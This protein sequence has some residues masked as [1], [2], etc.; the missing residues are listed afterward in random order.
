[1]IG[2]TTPNSQSL[3]GVSPSVCYRTNGQ[4]QTNGS[5]TT[6]VATF[7]TG[8]LIAIAVDM[9]TSGGQIT[10]YKN[11]VSVATVTGLISQFAGAG[12]FINFGCQTNAAS[13]TTFTAN[14]GQRAWAYSPPAGFSALT[15]KNFPRP[16]VGSAAATPNKYFDTVLYVGAGASQTV[17]GLKFQPDLIW[18]KDRT[19]TTNWYCIDSVRG[20]GKALYQNLT[21]AEAVDTNTI[22]GFTATGF[23]INGVSSILNTASD[24]YVAWC[25]YTGATAVSNTTGTITSSVSANTTSG[26]SIVTY[27]GAGAGVAS[28]VGHGLTTAP[29]FIIA[30]VRSTTNGW[31]VYHSSIGATYSSILSGTNAFTVQTDWNNTAP[32]TSVFSIT[33]GN[34]N[35][36]SATYVAYCWSEVP[37]FSKF[38]SYAGNNV[39]DGPF[40]YCGFKPR[41]IMIK[42][43]NTANTYTS[44]QIL[45]T[46]RQTNGISATSLWANQI[47]AEGTRGDGTADS[48]IGYV[49]I[50]SN[51]FKIRNTGGSYENNAGGASY[52][53]V[54]FADVPFGN[55]NG[56]AR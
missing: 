2:I 55:V 7:T 18:V 29:S 25:W 38:G 11:G 37:G 3:S 1:L 15:L 48:G 34:N 26:F 43:S 42:N 8:D 54:A 39:A 46:V 13:T 51:G 45:D 36:A 21:N 56:T 47:F 44:W 19:S 23:T 9:T 31:L 24:N 6:T 22:N 16:A 32:T 50:V 41:W 5:T 35:I 40:I 33:G 30:K 27:T 10:F 4:I 49:D 52:I 12:N 14:F 20:Q 53:Y 17:S 28:T